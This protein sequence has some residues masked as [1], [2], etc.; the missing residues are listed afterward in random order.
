MRLRIKVLQFRF[1]TLFRKSLEAIQ[2]KDPDPSGSNISFIA[3]AYDVRNKLEYPEDVDIYDAVLLTGSG[4]SPM[5][6]NRRRSTK[7]DITAA[8]AYEDVP[9]INKL[10]DYAKFVVEEKPKIRVIGGCNCSRLRSV[11][12]NAIYRRHM[13]WTS[14][15]RARDGWRMRAEWG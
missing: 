15:N 3:D 7:V 9:W 8:S 4:E 5:V 1:R 13:F 6:C 14:N 12:F 10:V 2:L 11:C